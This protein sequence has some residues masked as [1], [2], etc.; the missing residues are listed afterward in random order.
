MGCFDDGQPVVELDVTITTTK[1]DAQSWHATV[2]AFVVT[3]QKC[4][5]AFVAVATYLQLELL[6][7]SFADKYRRC[8][9]RD[10]NSVGLGKVV[11][12]PLAG[13]ST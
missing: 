7:N 1:C 3:H 8:V 11:L 9:R 5:S 4:L 6:R 2:E 10:P 13:M 12:A